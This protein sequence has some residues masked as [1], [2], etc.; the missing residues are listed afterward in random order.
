MGFHRRLPSGYRRE[1]KAGQ[2]QGRDMSQAGQ[3]SG[4]RHP[5]D[6]RSSQ[7][8]DAY[9]GCTGAPVVSYVN[10]GPLDFDIPRDERSKH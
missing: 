9:Q 4:H 3:P 2:I 8:V 7:P 1:A 6:V 5:I 10:R